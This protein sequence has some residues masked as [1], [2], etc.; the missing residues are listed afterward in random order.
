M[1]EYCYQVCLLGYRSSHADEIKHYLIECLA[2]LGLPE[3]YI[4]FLNKEDVHSRNRKAPC[5][6]VFSGYSDA[7]KNAHPELDG[8][9]EDSVLIVPIVEDLAKFGENVPSKIKH[10]NGVDGVL[11]WKIAC[12]SILEYFKLLRSERRLFI[13]YK[14]SETTSIAHQLYEAFDSRGYDVFL[15]TR[16]VPVGDIF[17]NVLWHRMA[18]SDVV[19]LLDSPSFHQSKWTEKEYARAMASKIHVEHLLWPGVVS[20]STAAF[21]QFV[22]I[23]KSDFETIDIIGNAARFTNSVIDKIVNDVESSR[24]RALAA[25]NANIIDDFCDLAREYGFKADL[26]PGHSIQLLTGKQEI[27]VVP[28]VGVPTALRLYKLFTKRPGDEVWALF[29]SLGIME[30]VVT[31]IAWL[32]QNLPMTAVPKKDIRSVLEGL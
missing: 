8:L 23:E 5:A 17:Q 16:S 3:E 14:R 9:I 19:V 1:T 12:I 31:H 28:M 30:D 26:Q 22:P 10:F 25:R 4:V 20:T 11:G 6:V 18:D 2:D 29:E 21:D 24:A 32:N 13:S 15:D 27:A 7:P